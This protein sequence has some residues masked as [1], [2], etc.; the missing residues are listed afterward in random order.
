MVGACYHIFGQA[1][2][3]SRGLTAFR[4]NDD[5]LVNR[6]H[7]YLIQRLADDVISLSLN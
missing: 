4:N 7:P 3:W 1:A 6:L 2:T 5:S